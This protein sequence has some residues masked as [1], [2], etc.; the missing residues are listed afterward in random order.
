MA[1]VALN[2]MVYW[3]LMHLYSELGYDGGDCLINASTGCHKDEVPLC[4]PPLGYV[5]SANARTWLHRFDSLTYF[6]G[7]KHSSPVGAVRGDAAVMSKCADRQWLGES[8]FSHLMTILVAA[9]VS[10]VIVCCRRST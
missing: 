3:S 10:Y 4:P 6:G 8:G 7:W 5:P 9:L 1:V 2:G